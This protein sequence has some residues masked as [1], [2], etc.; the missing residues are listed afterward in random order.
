MS[1]TFGIFISTFILANKRVYTCFLVI[2]VVVVFHES[3]QRK[4]YIAGANGKD[5]TR[6]A[7][8]RA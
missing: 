7:D 4:R 8:P 3:I 1:L 2:V 6:M 5:A